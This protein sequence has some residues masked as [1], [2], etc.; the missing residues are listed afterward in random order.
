M[1]QRLFL[2]PE[3]KVDIREAYEWYEERQPGLGKQFLASLRQ[4]LKQIELSS[5][6][7]RKARGEARRA[8]LHR[9]PYAVFFL[10]EEERIVV[11]ACFHARRD[12]RH[13]DR[14]AADS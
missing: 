10:V 9:F 3:A 14:R 8:A 7:F 12:P 4:V 5:L 2:R 6:R 11:F 1:T 13:L